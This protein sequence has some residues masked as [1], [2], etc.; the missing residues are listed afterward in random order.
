[1]EASLEDLQVATDVV[2]DLDMDDRSKTYHALF[3]L[4]A[5]R[6][7]DPGLVAPA[8][9]LAS[10]KQEFREQVAAQAY[11]RPFVSYRL[12]AIQVWTRRQARAQSVGK[13]QTSVLKLVSVADAVLGPV[14]LA[15]DVVVVGTKTDSG[16]S[17][18]ELTAESPDAG[19]AVAA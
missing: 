2:S 11:P 14:D 13:S 17:P 1:M 5:D 12:V 15:E 9:A 16:H 4:A 8:V 7:L 10:R 19:V 18:G 6:A 3:V